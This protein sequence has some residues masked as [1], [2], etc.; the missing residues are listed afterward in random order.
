WR[1][2]F[3]RRVRRT[4]KR[5]RRAVSARWPAGTETR[6]EAC[7]A[8]WRHADV[9]SRVRMVQLLRDATV[10]GRQERRGT[11]ADHAGHVRLFVASRKPLARILCRALRRAGGVSRADRGTSYGDRTWRFR[12]GD[13]VF[14]S[15]GGR[16]SWPPV[17]KRRQRNRRALRHHAELHG[18]MERAISG[19]LRS[20]SPVALQ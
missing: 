14:R 10:L 17:Q 20:L 12:G 7:R 15:A 18:E 6:A 3:P 5:S 1:G 13:C 4:K 11:D 16:R 19:L 8:A 9:R 2:F